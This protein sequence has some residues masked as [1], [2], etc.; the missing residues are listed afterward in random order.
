MKKS[1][2]NYNKLKNNN[3]KLYKYAESLRKG[4]F[5]MTEKTVLNIA[6][7]AEFMEFLTDFE[8]DNKRL[9]SGH[10]C[11][12]RFCPICSK[13][14]SIRQYL[15]ILLMIYLHLINYLT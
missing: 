10:F 9:F 14:K 8:K 7:C 5:P 1:Q 3:K 13:R 2:E 12:N 11:Q 15:K 6:S 4:D